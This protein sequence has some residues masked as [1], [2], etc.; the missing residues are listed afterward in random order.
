MDP[1]SLLC[2]PLPSASLQSVSGRVQATT[3]VITNIM[4]TT[5]ISTIT[6]TNVCRTPPIRR[7]SRA[8]TRINSFNK[9]YNCIWHVLLLTLFTDG[10]LEM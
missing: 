5:I 6:V 10:E 7:A 4:A 1:L 9:Y 3:L 8:L 2:I